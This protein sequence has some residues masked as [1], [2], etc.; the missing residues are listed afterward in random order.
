MRFRL[1]PRSMTLD[2][3]ELLE[4]SNFGG[5]LRGYFADLGG[6]NG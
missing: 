6:N 5:I 1:T 3:L 2:E 4:C